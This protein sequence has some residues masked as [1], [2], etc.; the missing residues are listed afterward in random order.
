MWVA[1]VPAELVLF[2]RG[3]IHVL[4]VSVGLLPVAGAAIALL[5]ELVALGE[6]VGSTQRR[7]NRKDRLEKYHCR[8]ISFAVTY[9][10]FLRLYYYLIMIASL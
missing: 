3:D 10:L 2:V 7:A 1:S 6:R 4:E 9:L 8:F 5:G